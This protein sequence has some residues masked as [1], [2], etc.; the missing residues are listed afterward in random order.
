[1]FT[2]TIPQRFFDDTFTCDCF[3]DF[4]EADYAQLLA[5]CKKTKPY[6]VNLT[7]RDLRELYERATHYADPW[8]RGEFGIGIVRSADYTVSAIREQHPQI[9]GEMEAGA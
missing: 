6:T 2:V 9:V 3:V 1:M 8:M 4:T 5:T 7:E